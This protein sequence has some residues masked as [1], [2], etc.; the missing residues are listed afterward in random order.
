MKGRPFSVVGNQILLV[1]TRSTNTFSS[2]N[3]H[4]FLHAGFLLKSPFNFFLIVL[5]GI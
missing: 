3:A 2:S 1:F 5:R 4:T